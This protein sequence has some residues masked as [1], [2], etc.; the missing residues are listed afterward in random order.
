[1]PEFFYSPVFQRALYSLI[2]I[3]TAYV[4]IAI[5]RRMI[6]KQVKDLKRRHAARKT[7]VYIFSF[8]TI[9]IIAAIWVQGGRSLAT[10]FGVVGA[11]LTLALHQPVTSIAGWLLLL[12][13]RPYET[14][15]RVEI[16]SV[17]GDVIDIRLFYTSMLEIGNWVDADQSTGRIVHC[18]NSK[19]FSEP[20]FNYTRG[21][22][23]VW[24]EIKIAIT[25]E[26]DVKRAR[27]IILEV[28]GE[29]SLDLD[30]AVQKRMR[31]MSRKYLI[32]F[33]KLTPIVWT[34]IV[35]FGVELTLRFLTDARKRRSSEDEISL[36]ILER[37]NQEDMIE[38]AY[39]TYRIYKRGEP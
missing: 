6:N 38:L 19:I 9:L 11:G 15:D 26:S 18:P 17:K 4:S 28:A 5:I 1:M 22:E 3:L 21:F 16:G 2:T 34:R 27:E 23:Y 33:S 12:I 32:H 31:T 37:F 20:I 7:I 14:G 13:R 35:D 39:P 36:A 8:L 24:H 25:F 29:K 30:K 10:L